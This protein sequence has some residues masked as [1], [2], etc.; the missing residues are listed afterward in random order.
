LRSNGSPCH[1]AEQRDE[2]AAPHVGLH[3]GKLARDRKPQAGAA[4]ALRRRGVGLGTFWGTQGLDR[5]LAKDRPGLRLNE[6]LEHGQV[7]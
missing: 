2:L 6:H 4:E 1:T 3:A 7:K 5:V